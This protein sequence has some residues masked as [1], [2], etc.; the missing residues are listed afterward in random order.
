MQSIWYMPMW[1]VEW[2][3]IELALSSVLIW[4]LSMVYILIGT[5]F[6]FLC[7]FRGMLRM[8][9]AL[10]TKHIKGLYEIVIQ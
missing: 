6:F 9:L 7:L 2:L 5:E 4:P 3:D 8:Y 1:Y 10:W